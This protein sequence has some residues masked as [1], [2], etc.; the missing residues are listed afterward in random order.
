M[1]YEELNQYT[2]KNQLYRDKKYSNLGIKESIG[3]FKNMI[4]QYTHTKYVSVKTCIYF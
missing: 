1:P 2:G 4:K 3:S